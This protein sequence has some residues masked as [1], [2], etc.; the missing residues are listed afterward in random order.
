[1]TRHEYNSALAKLGASPAQMAQITGIGIRTPYRWAAGDRPIPAFV[2]VILR[3][4]LRTGIRPD[5]LGRVSSR[6]AA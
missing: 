4:W 6:K 1:M 2:A 5:E 3:Y